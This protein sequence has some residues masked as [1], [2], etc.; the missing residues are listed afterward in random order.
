MYHDAVRELADDRSGSEHGQN[1]IV[2][3]SGEV[4]V[5]LETGDVSVCKRL[6]IDI[7]EKRADA[8][9]GQDEE[10]YVA[11]RQTKSRSS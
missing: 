10:V 3:V 7:V 1:D 4:D 2:V 8:A 5:F 6:P 9:I 11:K